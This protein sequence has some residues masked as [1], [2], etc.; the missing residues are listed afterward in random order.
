MPTRD[1]LLVMAGICL[2]CAIEIVELHP[3]VGVLAGIVGISIVL[4]VKLSTPHK[5]ANTTS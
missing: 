1:Y 2:G 5:N 4:L 3:A